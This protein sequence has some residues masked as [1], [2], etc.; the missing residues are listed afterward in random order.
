MTPAKREAI[1]ASLAQGNLIFL[2]RLRD[3]HIYTLAGI[4]GLR[5]ADVEELLAEGKLEH[6]GCGC[7]R[8]WRLTEC[9]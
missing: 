4:D 5:R 2:D 9:K 3:L 8:A 6:A 7:G 1:L